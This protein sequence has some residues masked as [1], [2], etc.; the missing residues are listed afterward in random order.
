ME[1]L[2]HTP[3]P[4]AA[5]K[6]TWLDVLVMY[7]TNMQTPNFSTKRDR[8]YRIKTPY[9]SI[10]FLHNLLTYILYK[11]ASDFCL[12]SLAVAALSLIRGF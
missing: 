11:E 1:L 6:M 2:G 8:R 5:Y 3:H 9:H 7:L 10:D 12:A 4:F